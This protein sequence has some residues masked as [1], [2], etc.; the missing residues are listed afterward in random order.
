MGVH[1]A[2][3]LGADELLLNLASWLERALPW[4]ARSAALMG[5]YR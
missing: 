4:H 3:R 2:A 5:R 1:F